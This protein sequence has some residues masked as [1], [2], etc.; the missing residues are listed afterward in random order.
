MKVT[1]CQ[2]ADNQ[3]QFRKD[4]QELR[5][6]LDDNKTDLLLLPE[7]P[8]YKWLAA[9]K[10]VSTELKLESVRAH[11]VWLSQLEKLNADY[12][13]YSAPDFSDNKFLNTSF[14]FHKET[15]HRKV[16][17]KA[18]FPEEP[19]FWEE[20]WFDREKH[21]SFEAYDL[22]PF[23]IGV[24]LCTELWFTDKARIYGKQ[25]VD[26][27]LCPRATGKSTVERW[28]TCGSAAAIISGAYCLSSNRS[29]YGENNFEWG[30]TGWI[31]EPIT[32]KIMDTTS[33]EKKFSTQIIDLKK[34]ALAKNEYPLN[35]KNNL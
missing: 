13:V 10:D 2:L 12:I 33:T 34:S 11:G 18:L 9:S 35:V 1:I 20:T 31:A 8:F 24:L 5:H 3:T 30:G 7:M 23:S 17:T 16:H 21:I 6:H 29:G 32:G 22:G 27:L 4:W 25:N 15:G 19:H 28:L 14:V 26:I